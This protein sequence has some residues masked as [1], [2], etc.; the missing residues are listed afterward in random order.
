MSS[1][2]PAFLQVLFLSQQYQCD[3]GPGQKRTSSGW[4][5]DLLHPRLGA[6]TAPGD[7]DAGKLGDTDVDKALCLSRGE[8]SVHRN[9]G[10]HFICLEGL[11]YLL[12]LNSITCIFILLILMT[13]HTQQQPEPGLRGARTCSGAHTALWIRELSSLPT[14]ETLA[15][16][17]SGKRDSC[18]SAS[19]RVGISLL[20]TQTRFP[21]EDKTNGFLLT[22]LDTCVIFLFSCSPRSPSF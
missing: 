15:G 16:F 10:K 7:A 3:P 21:S 20:P 1:R 12:W 13:A 11:L 2:G 5:P 9:R 14:A 8:P 6:L 18:S 19:A 4:P 22:R 17:A